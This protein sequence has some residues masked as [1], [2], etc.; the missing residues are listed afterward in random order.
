M[1]TGLPEVPGGCAGSP[2]SN[3]ELG[4]VRLSGLCDSF[5]G[6]GATQLR[7]PSASAQDRLFWL[8]VSPAGLRGCG[9]FA[10]GCQIQASHQRAHQV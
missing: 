10:H 2:N 8:T 5:E 4:A 9:L 1:S 7:I 6:T 3:G